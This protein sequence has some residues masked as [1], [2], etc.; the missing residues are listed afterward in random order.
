M[1]D[2]DLAGIAPLMPSAAHYILVAPDAPRAL[3]EAE[4]EKQLRE[5]RPELN[6]QGAGSVA[7]GISKAL[8][9]AS[10]APGEPLVY[11]GGSTFVVTEAVDYYKHH[12]S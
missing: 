10:A 1:R 3:P 4:L 9:N 2:K 8:E 11:I 6:V 5:L 7:E 12:R